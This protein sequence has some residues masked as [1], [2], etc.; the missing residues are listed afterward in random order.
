MSQR[1]FTTDPSSPPSCRRTGLVAGAPVPSVEGR[2][3]AR[4]PGLAESRC[5]QI[6][7][8]ADLAGRRAQ[9]TPEVLDRRATPEP[10]AVVDAVYDQSRLQHERVRDHRVVVGVGVLL[11]VEVLLD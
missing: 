1:R 7:V 10:V 9:I 6:P 8:R 4:G 11:D 3:V 2:A 5:A